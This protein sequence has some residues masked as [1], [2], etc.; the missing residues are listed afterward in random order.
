MFYSVIHN[1]PTLSG[2]EKLRYLLSYLSSF[3]KKLIERLPLT[4]A[5]YEIALDILKK[6]YDNKRVM[7]SAYV[8]SIISY[9]KMN[10]GSA[11]DAIRLHDAVD[12]CLSGLKK[13][14][15]DVAHWV[16][17]MVAIVTSKFDVETNKAF[18]ESL[19][20]ITKVPDMEFSVQCQKNNRI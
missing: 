2:V 18:E 4:N 10:N 1:N 17:I 8:N 13:L 20:D 5:N 19:S 15:Y 7:V 3:P 12:S 11:G 14:G 16:P 9:K 6:R